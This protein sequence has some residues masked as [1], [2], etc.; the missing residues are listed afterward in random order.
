MKDT[1]TLSISKEARRLAKIAA[2]ERD[3]SLKDYIEELVVAADRERAKAK[4]A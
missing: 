3:I 2:A 1:T 4:A